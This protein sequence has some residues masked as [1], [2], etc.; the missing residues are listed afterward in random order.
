MTEVGLFIHNCIE[1]GLLKRVVMSINI[2]GTVLIIKTKHF[3]SIGI[4]VKNA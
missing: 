4:L 2:V 1:F 3:I